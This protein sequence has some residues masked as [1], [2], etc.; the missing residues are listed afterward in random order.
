MKLR[1]FQIVFVAAALL[2]AVLVL[3]HGRPH[4]LAPTQAPQGPSGP[5]SLNGPL[6]PLQKPTAQDRKAAIAAIQAQLDAFR[7]GDFKAAMRYQS[8]G[9]QQGIPSSAAF[10]QM[11]QRQYPAFLHFQSVTFQKA[12]T[13]DHGN[14]VFFMIA[15]HMP[16]KSQV[17]AIYMMSREGGVYKVNGVQGGMQ[18]MPGP[19]PGLSKFKM[20]RVIDPRQAGDED[21]VGVGDD[22]S[23][24]ALVWA[25]RNGIFPWPMTGSPLFWFCPPQRAILDF[26][27]LHVPRRLARRQ[28][29]AGLTFTIDRDFPA[30]IAACQHAFRPRQDGTWI[31]PAMTQAYTALHRAGYAHSAEA[32]DAEGHLVGGVYG[33][34]VAGCFSGES[35]FHTVPDASKLA[36]LHLIIH[37]QSRGITWID[38]QMM[39]PH[40]DALGATLISRDAFLNRLEATQQQGLQAFDWLTDYA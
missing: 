30:V 18:G 32:W 14:H 29:H 3:R 21:I 13:P 26:A 1:A 6:G 8:R 25:Y 36:L 16:D 17:Q 40:M 33:V 11:M 22:L 4:L 19:P 39:T 2:C 38:I 9:M 27:D 24:E 31:T 5:I 23:I 10:Q 12:R 15:L 34:S 28:R 37:L 20:L 7:K 35:M